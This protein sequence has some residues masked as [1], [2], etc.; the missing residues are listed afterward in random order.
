MWD[1]TRNNIPYRT[2]LKKTIVFDNAFKISISLQIYLD[3]LQW[4]LLTK[5]VSK[6]KWSQRL[7]MVA[8]R[9]LSCWLAVCALRARPSAKHW[10]HVR[11]VTGSA[12]WS[13]PHS[14]MDPRPPGGDPTDFHGPQALWVSDRQ[15]GL[16]SRGRSQLAAGSQPFSA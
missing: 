5:K 16:R 8:T 15:Q 13:S 7:G 4:I 9:H 6:R 10:H 3:Q 2:T 12:P 11:C 14:H 1:K